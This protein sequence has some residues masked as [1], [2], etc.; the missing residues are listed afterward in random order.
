MLE[1]MLRTVLFV[2]GNRPGMLQKIVTLAADAFILDLEDSVPLSEKEA[3]RRMV[4]EAIGRHGAAD[5]GALCVR[6][7]ALPSGLTNGDLDAVVAPGLEGVWYPKA[8]TVDEVQ[9]VDGLL[10][11]AEALMGLPAGHLDMIVGIESVRGL[12]NAP[13][14]ATASPRLAALAFGGE[15]FATDLGIQ[16]TRAGLE[17]DH[18]RAH[19][20]LAARSAGLEVLDSVCIHL[21]DDE[22]LAA[23]CQTARQ[24]GYTGKAAIHPRQLETITRVFSPSQGQV[25]YARRVVAAFEAVQA[26]G[27]AAIAVDGQMMDIA[28]LERYR[29]LLS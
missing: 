5:R 14:I 7:N 3:A 11:H 15:D 25:A 20:A 24:M 4:R 28:A 26:A 10:S 21:E 6:V 19:V 18:A 9:A 13:Q 23:E 8:E 12:Q 29:R 2:P 16:R 1:L 22:Q 17:L 27:S